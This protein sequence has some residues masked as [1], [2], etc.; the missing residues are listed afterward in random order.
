MTTS[1]DSSMSVWETRRRPMRTARRAASLI[2]LARSAPEAPGVW[3]ATAPK[4]MAD[5]ILTS[6]ACSLRMDSRPARSGSSTGMRRSKRPGRSSARS[7]ESGRFVAARTTMPLW[8][9]KPSISARSWFRVCSR[10]SFVVRPVSRRLPMV[11]ISSMKT[12]QGAFSLACLKRSRTFAAPRPTNISTNSEPEIEKNGTLASPATALAS[13]V[14][15]VPGGPTS[16][17]PL[18]QRA[19]M[20]AYFSGCSRKETISSR[21]SLASSWPATSL[22]VMP[23]SSPLTSLAPERPSPAPKPRPPP[24]FMDGPSSPMAFLSLR[25]SSHA[26]PMRTMSGSM[27]MRR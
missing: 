8:L 25:L 21:E 16:R 12:M 10:S 19:P 11:S 7:S 13:S 4:S 15:P 22:K 20:A 17:A 6:F 2:M 9:S 27:L 23:V 3:R 14:L 24:K 26:P 5:S 1:T 18:G